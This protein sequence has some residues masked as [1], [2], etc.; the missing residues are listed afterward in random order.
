MK[1]IRLNYKSA[2]M[3][4]IIFILLFSCA[5]ILLHAQDDRKEKTDSVS[6]LVVKYFNDKNAEQLYALG[7]D[8]FHHALTEDAFKNVCNTNLFPLGEIKQTALENY[9][10]GVCKYKAI[11]NT[12]TLTLLLSLDKTDRI[13]VFL[14][15]PYVDETQRKNYKVP[16]TNSLSTQLD[17]EVDSAVQPYISLQ[18]TAGL[19]IGILKDAKALFYGYGETAKGNKQIPD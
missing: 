15:K 4:K 6:K 11:F 8:D 9:E 18:A 13:G 3:K 1:P 12:V 7:G 17:K 16:S 5:A 10:N 19:S 14:F 2:I